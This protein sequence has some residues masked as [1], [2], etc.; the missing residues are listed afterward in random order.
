MR[1]INEATNCKKIA[2]LGTKKVKRILK[3]K[4][5]AYQCL[6]YFDSNN[7]RLSADG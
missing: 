7:G 5:N 2:Y 1:A 4:G 6:K 3:M